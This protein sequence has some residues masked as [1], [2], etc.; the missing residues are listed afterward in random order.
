MSHQRIP[1]GTQ[2]RSLLVYQNADVFVHWRPA[3]PLQ[4]SC[5]YHTFGNPT[6]LVKKCRTSAYFDMI[7][8]QKASNELTIEEIWLRSALCLSK[9]VFLR[10]G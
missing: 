8:Q 9:C 4:H 5:R 7:A 2:L 1:Q 6:P 10:F 3:V